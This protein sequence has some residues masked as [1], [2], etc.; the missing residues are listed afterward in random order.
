M[1]R[2]LALFL[3]AVLLLGCGCT[4]RS[5]EQAAAGEEY[6]LYFLAAD[7]QSSAGGG[8]L[9]SE[10]L[11]LEENPL[12]TQSL[13]ELL[14]QELL[15]GPEGEGLKSTIPGGT[16]LLSVTLQGRK[17]VVDLSYG[18]ATLSGIGLTL[19]DNAIALT[20]TQLPEILAV[21]IT[22]RGQE[23]AYR[24]Q[25]LFTGRNVLLLPE[26]DVVGTVNATLH[27]LNEDGWLT[28][29]KTELDLYEGDTQVSAVIAAL[30]DGPEEKGISSP[31]PE[32]FYIRSAWQ[33][34]EVCYVNLSSALLEEL[35]GVGQAE[36]EQILQ[37]IAWSLCSLERIS[38]TRFL[39][40]GDFADRYG[41]VDVSEPFTN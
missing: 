8:A 21:E 2:K 12:D 9:E 25:T 26:G 38:E 1:K 33:E 34:E 18:Y 15:D 22:V 20:L 5:V 39:V 13:A 32:G 23:L 6:D 36:M 27:F 16:S 17:A 29:R 28:P 19:A 10:K 7:Y 30:M 35:D 37:S 4:Y 24:E 41:F 40:D 3:C 14:M 31:F 11:R